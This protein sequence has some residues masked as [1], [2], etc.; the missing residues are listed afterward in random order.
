MSL[1]ATLTTKDDLLADLLKRVE[2]IKSH[3]NGTKR[4]TIREASNLR[5][6]TDLVNDLEIKMVKQMKAMDIKFTSAL[7]ITKQPQ[8]TTRVDD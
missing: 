1:E 3:Q 7:K 2:S 4:S 6:H 8:Q 5:D